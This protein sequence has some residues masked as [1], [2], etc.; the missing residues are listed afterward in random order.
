MEF[1]EQL[2]KLNIFNPDIEVLDIGCYNGW[3]FQ[4]LKKLNRK[5]DL[6]DTMDLVPDKTGARFSKNL[7]LILCQI[8]NMI[9]FLH[10]MYF[11]F[12]LSRLIKQRDIY[13]I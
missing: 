5:F 1:T 12:V 9:L 11:S 3:L 7:L 2:K 10:A 6:V 8:K 4:R 13:N